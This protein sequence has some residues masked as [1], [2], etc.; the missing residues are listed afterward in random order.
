[1]LDCHNRTAGID[2]GPSGRGGQWVRR[3][4]VCA[5]ALVGLYA[6]ALGFAVL[7]DTTNPYIALRLHAGLPQA[8]ERAADLRLFS[9]GQQALDAIGKTPRGVLPPSLTSGIGLELPDRDEAAVKAYARA[10]LRSSPL[11]SASLRQL[12]FFEDDPK[13]RGRLLDLANQVTRRDILATL[14]RAELKLRQNDVEGGL[15]DLDQ[16]LVVST[17]VDSVVFP[18]LLGT[19]AANEQLAGAVRERLSREPPWSERMMRWAIANPSYLSTLTKVLDAFPAHSAARSPGFGQQVVDLLASQRQFPEAFTAYRAFN[20][21]GPDLSNMTRSAYEPIDWKLVDNFDTGARPFDEGQVEIS[22]NPGRT[23]E[24]AQVVTNFPAGTRRL[25]LRLNET[26]GRGGMMHF[27]AVC[28]FGRTERI[29]SER[30]SPLRNG[31]VA[32]PFSIPT[33]G[34]PFQRLTLRIEG[35]TEAASAL[36]RSVSFG[37]G[38]AASGK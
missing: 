15:A 20:S 25:S 35:G 14:H 12:A 34:C 27:A 17:T 21:A 32:F 6:G 5:G 24:F 26:L 29:A 18:L 1:M 9:V 30:E 13:Q 7:N 28:L 23:G 3:L 4:F 33:S 38:G 8:T 37:E 36:I 22:A 16:S 31:I 19:V 2:V 10:A 11:S